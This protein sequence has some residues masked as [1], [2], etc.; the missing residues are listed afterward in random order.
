MSANLRLAYVR[1]LFAQPVKKVDEVSTGT[2]ANTVTS[3]ANTIQLSISDKLHL[4]FSSIALTIA[5]YVI[6]FKYSWALTLVTSS[7]I[8]FVLVVYSITTPIVIKLVQ[9][10]EA[11]DAKAA[12]VAGEVFGS[13]RTAFSLGAEEQLT[14]K[15]YQS[16]AHSQTTGLRISRQFGMQLA[17]IFFAMY[18]S[19]ALAFWYGIK[20][21]RGGHIH[22]V[23]T[24]IM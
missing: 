4:L 22:D 24:V 23:S 3:S 6:A 16:V 2:I 7:A 21:Y 5:A 17:P 19:F 11:A 15:Y 9:K 1:A 8:V 12:S 18:S 20:L 13:I 14:E 10:L